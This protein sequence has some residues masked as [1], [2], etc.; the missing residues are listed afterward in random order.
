MNTRIVVL[1]SGNSG[2]LAANR[3]RRY[4]DGDDVRIIVIDRR[5]TRDQ[6]TDLLIALGLYGPHALLAP[7]HL[8]LRDGIELRHAEAATV[9]PYGREVYLTDGTTVAYDV[10]VLATGTPRLRGERGPLQV[11]PLTRRSLAHPEVFAVGA[12]AADHMSTSPSI[13]VQAENMARTVQ[14]LLADGGL[15]RR[16]TTS[17]DRTGTPAAAGP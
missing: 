1:G 3:L 2:T 11:N 7:E 5:D 17:R 16:D 13:H 14:W 15:P 9:D 6:E 4:C 10:L 12:A 8:H